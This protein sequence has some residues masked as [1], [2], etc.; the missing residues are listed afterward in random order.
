M[1]IRSRIFWWGVKRF[2]IARTVQFFWPIA[3]LFGI[4]RPRQVNYPVLEFDD[5]RG[6]P[7]EPRRPF[8][9]LGIIEGE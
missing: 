7:D 4:H 5:R 8:R 3:R 2:E 6:L 1:E 9:N